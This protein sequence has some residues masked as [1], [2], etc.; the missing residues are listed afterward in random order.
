ML[1]PFQGELL[2]NRENSK[3]LNVPGALRLSPGDTKA[4]ISLGG[5]RA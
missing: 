2:F 4:G 3:D 1:S 5:G